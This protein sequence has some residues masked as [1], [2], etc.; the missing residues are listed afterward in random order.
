[1]EE[2]APYSAALSSDFLALAFLAGFSAAS[3]A[4]ASSFLASVFFAAAFLAGFG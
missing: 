1:L 2:S 3:A 4:G